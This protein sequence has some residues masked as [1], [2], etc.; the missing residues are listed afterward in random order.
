MRTSW[1][2]IKVI[3]PAYVGVTALAHTPVL[4]WMTDALS[5][6]MGLF[7]LR[8]EAAMVLVLGNVTNLYGAL[9]AIASLDF[10]PK[11]VT[12]MALML[13]FSHSLLVETAVT[14]RLGV[15]FWGVLCFRVGLA[16]ATGLLLH[17]LDWLW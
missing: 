13:S 3:A 14:K 5:G 1:D 6:V 12:I 7:G 10:T 8:G 11:E 9:G 17:R 15:A 4:E 16:V 2:L